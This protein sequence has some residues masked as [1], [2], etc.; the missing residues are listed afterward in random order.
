MG[1][2]T[3]ARYG[4]RQAVAALINTNKTATAIVGQFRLFTDAIVR[5]FRVNVVTAGTTAAGAQKLL[6][7]KNTTSIGEA[8]IGTNTSGSVVDASLTDTTFA[9][10]DSMVIKSGHSD[11][12]FKGVV[13]VDYNEIFN[14]S[15]D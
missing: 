11:A 7:Y 12:T 3:D 2:Y 5:E 15:N 6:F 13:M 9:S 1:K 14:N 10:T 8:A 4:C